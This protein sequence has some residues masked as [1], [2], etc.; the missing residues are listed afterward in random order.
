MSCDGWGRSAFT[1]N[2]CFLLCWFQDEKPGLKSGLHQ[3]VDEQ[4]LGTF[5]SVGDVKKAEGVLH[6]VSVGM[7]H[8]VSV[9]MLHSVSAGMP[10]SVSVGV[11]HSVSAGMPHSVSVG[12]LHSVSQ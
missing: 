11:L 8:S 3:T 9:G 10:H 12:V 7:P 5:A 4:L 1:L 6:S 2:H